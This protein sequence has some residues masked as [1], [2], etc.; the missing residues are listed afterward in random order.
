MKLFKRS[1]SVLMA[2]LM[3]FSQPLM[4]LAD[5]E[6]TEPTYVGGERLEDVPEG[7]YVYFGNAAITLQEGDGSFSVPIYR[8]G[9]TSERAWVKIHTIDLTSVYGRDYRV[10]GKHRTEHA[11]RKNIFQLLAEDNNSDSTEIKNYEF[12]I[13]NIDKASPTEVKK[14]DSAD[15]KAQEPDSYE[16]E[17]ADPD[18]ETLDGG[19]AADDEFAADD[20]AALMDDEFA[21]D[22]ADD[23]FAIDDGQPADDSGIDTDNENLKV[24]NVNQV[25]SGSISNDELRDAYNEQLA[26]L[27][28]ADADDTDKTVNNEDG[29]SNGNNTNN[30]NDGS[31]NSRDKSGTDSSKTITA[32]EQTDSRELS[33]DTEA[34][35]AE[36]I[37]QKAVVDADTDSSTEDDGISE[38]AKLKY[39]QT[40]VPTREGTP[41]GVVNNNITDQI[42]GAIA[43]EYMSLISYS[44]EQTIYFEPDEDE[45]EFTFRLYDNRKSDGSRMFSVIIAE[46][47]DNIETYKA[48]NMSVLIEDDEETAHSKLSFADEQFDGTDNTAEIKIVRSDLLQTMATAVLTAENSDTGETETL[49]ELVFSPYEKEKTIR[50]NITH[51]S[52]LRLTD[53]T[54]ADEGDIM[55]AIVTGTDNMTGEYGIAVDEDTAANEAMAL[56]DNVAGADEA[57]ALSDNEAVALA[58]SSSSSSDS[59][60]EKEFSLTFN[61]KTLTGVYKNGDLKATLYDRTYNPALAVGDYFFAAD[62]KNGG[63]FSYEP[64]H[65]DGDQPGWHG[66]AAEAFVFHSDE[67]RNN[68]DFRQSHGWAH[69]YTKGKASLEGAVRIDPVLSKASP[70]NAL[71]YQYICPEMSMQT[72]DALFSQDEWSSFRIGPKSFYTGGQ[73]KDQTAK[74]VRHIIGKFG[75]GVNGHLAVK[76]STENSLLY[77]AVG[78]EDHSAWVCKTFINFSGMVAMYKKYIISVED[79]EQRDYKSADGKSTTVPYQVKVKVGALNPTEST[80]TRDFYV[81][82]KSENSNIVFTVQA[83]NINGSIGTFGKLSGYRITIGNGNPKTDKTVN[84]PADF[85]S[86]LKDSN[87]ASTDAIDYSAEA[88]EKEVA[89]I[90]NDIAIVPVDIY[91]V[92]WMNSVSQEVVSDGMDNQ[93]WHQNLKFKPVIDYIDVNVQVTEPSISGKGLTSGIAH[94]KDSELKAGAVKTYHAGDMLDLTAVADNSAYRVIGYE[95]SDDGGVRFNHIENSTQL[96]LQAGSVKGYIIRP[97]V[98]PNE[99]YIEIKYASGADSYV[100]VDNLVPQDVLKDYPE[101]KGKNILDI[102]PQAKDIY[103]RIFPTVGRAY[104]V[105]VVFDKTQSGGKTVRATVKDSD[106]GKTYTTNK[107][108]FLA[109]NNRDNNKFEVGTQLAA[110]ADVQDYT[111]TGSAVTKAISVRQDGKGYNTLPTKGYTISLGSG[112]TEVTNKITNSKMSVVNVS[113]GTIADNGAFTLQGKS[114]S[115]GD[116]ITVLCTNGLGDDQI[117]EVKLGINKDKDG[118]Y[119]DNAGQLVMG[120]PVTAPEIKTVTYSYEKISSS[121]SVTLN[122]SQIRLLDDTLNLTAVVDNKGR[123]IDSVRFVVRDSSGNTKELTAKP[124]NGKSNN[125]FEVSVKNMLNYFHTGDKIYAYVVD[126]DS[127]TINYGSTTKKQQIVYPQVDT[128]LSTYVENEKITPKTYEQENDAKKAMPNVDLPIIGGPASGT[129]SG[130][131]TFNKVWHEGHKSYSYTANIDALYDN[132]VD[133]AKDKAN[134]TKGAA[135]SL[136]KAYKERKAKMQRR[137]EREEQ[138]QQPVER[139]ENTGNVS[140]DEDEIDNLFYRGDEASELSGQDMQDEEV[141]NAAADQAPDAKAKEMLTESYPRYA[142]NVYLCVD[143]EF[144][145]NENTNEFVLSMWSVVVGGKYSIEQV[146]YTFIAYFPVY[147]DLSGMI[148]LNVY[149]GSLTDSFKDA[150]KAG[151]FDNYSGNLK[152][153]ADGATVVGGTDATFKGRFQIGAGVMNCAGI[154]GGITFTFQFQF[155]QLG[156]ASKDWAGAVLGLS[157]SIGID[158]VVTQFNWTFGRVQKGWGTLSN[159]TQVEWLLPSQNDEKTN[160]A[161]QKSPSVDLVEKSQDDKDT[162]TKALAAAA[163][164]SLDD[165]ADNEAE[166][167][168]EAEAE[169]IEAA[170]GGYYSVSSFGLGSDLDEEGDEGFANTV[171]KTSWLKSALSLDSEEDLMQTLKVNAAERTRPQLIALDENKSKYMMLFIGKGKDSET[172]KDTAQLYYSINKRGG[173][174]GAWQTP[175]P[176]DAEDCHYDSSPDV[177]EVSPGKFMVAWLDAREPVNTDSFNTSAYTSFDVSGALFDFGSDLSKI[178][179][180]EIKKFTFSSDKTAYGD[181]EDKHYFN[182]AP[183]LTKSGRQIYCT[184]LKR[185]ISEVTSVEQLTD[186]TGSYSV[187]A[188]VCYDTDQL[189]GTELS[190]ERIFSQHWEGSDPDPY[191]T[192]YAVQGFTGSSADG[193]TES[194]YVAVAYTIDGD[195]DLRTGDDRNM[196]LSIYNTTDKL[197]YYPIKLT[198]DTKTQTMLQMNRLNGNIYLTWLEQGLQGDDG[199]YDRTEQSFSIMNI[200]DVIDTLLQTEGISEKYFYPNG[201]ATP[202][203]YGKATLTEYDKAASVNHKS[204]TR[205]GLSDSMDV[206]TRTEYRAATPTEYKET[207]ALSNTSESSALNDKVLL[208]AVRS[209]MNSLSVAYAGHAD[210]YNTPGWKYLEDGWM[211]SGNDWYSLNPE[212]MKEDI[213]NYLVA[214]NKGVEVGKDKTGK[215]IYYDRAYAESI[216]DEGSDYESID[217]VGI[218]RY[219][220]V[221]RAQNFDLPKYTAI[222]ADANGRSASSVNEYKLVADGENDIYVFF[223]DYCDN[224]DHTGQELYAMR[225]REESTAKLDDSKNDWEGESA[226]FSEPVMLTDRNKIIDEFDVQPGRSKGSIKIVS[227]LYDQDSGRNDL[228][229]FSFTAKGSV[230]PANI[231]IDEHIVKGSK[232]E[233]QFDLKNEGLYT[234][235]GCTL[236]LELELVDKNDKKLETIKVP[237]EL[238]KYLNSVQLQPGQSVSVVIPWTPDRDLDGTSLRITSTENASSL[239]EEFTRTSYSVTKAIPYKPVIEINDYKLSYENGQIIVTATVANHGNKDVS[240]LKLVL[241]RLGIDNSEDKVLITQNEGGLKSG[242]QKQVSFAYAPKVSDFDGFERIKLELSAVGDGEELESVTDTFTDSVPVVCEIEEGAERISINA[243]QTRQLEFKAAPYNELAGD[244]MFYSSDPTIAYVDSDGVLHA[245][246][247]GSVTITLY[248]PSLG[249]STS[250]EVNVVGANAERSDRVRNSD[251]YKNSTGTGTISVSAGIPGSAVYGLWTYHPETGRWTFAAGN[252]QY[253]NEWAYIYNPYAVELQDKNAWFRFDADGNMVTGWYTDTDGCIYYLWPYSDNT[254]GHMVTGWLPI[255][256]NW[257]FFNPVSNGLKGAMYRSTTT[258]DGYRVGEDGA[259]IHDMIPADQP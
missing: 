2:S 56:S 157:G 28:N 76:V 222:L 235:N 210:K 259:W 238:S 26:R 181:S 246:K 231:D 257:Y 6:S 50:L 174:A 216:Y 100:H 254:M 253:K 121:Q 237:S 190:Q 232:T 30:V 80:E 208:S 172:G 63:M 7:N 178:S 127:V 118:R 230:K 140:V 144:V 152:N 109:R 5:T 187:V 242:E 22:S 17:A 83:N 10:E 228:V 154:R 225:F 227:N 217:D 161:D 134:R 35:Q 98:A 33:D 189:D 236:E 95:I 179:K 20:A 67:A 245:L 175:K 146:Y 171:E 27:N 186:M 110:P 197:A 131:I 38:L 151:D 250:V 199:S 180:P 192:N 133:S 129:Q 243:G 202:T 54:A 193:L 137:A 8:E 88:V 194:N 176:V 203:E 104:S 45:A 206:A 55:S 62:D 213:I 36:V 70:I 160:A 43:P 142:V 72:T 167:E 184:Y 65:L 224:V 114:G 106:N 145:L 164:L 75:H 135:S 84:Y 251:R 252:R 183:Q 241:T 234:A 116:L 93:A 212:D 105:D 150:V 255:G 211:M 191:I 170:N 112:Q 107:Y 52:V 111:L 48:T 49:G 96:V 233:L 21:V 155:A 204:L 117:I 82:P 141:A 209:S 153:M 86:F 122:E 58:D 219:S 13:E 81:N 25:S 108:Y 31:N 44:C 130:L 239:F 69:Y 138:A 218:F 128:G 39:E 125:V 61:G 249:I 60:D 169:A 41:T 143:L 15:S 11:G 240:E 57:A 258:P 201:K 94:F 139:G 12:D 40:G 78:A 149:F 159:K 220:V 97:E 101:L 99:N 198:S 29:A 196:Y 23:G 215:S 147:L 1:I 168:T 248:Y 113:S 195:N 177:I 66:E 46:T 9:D 205:S 126:K 89:K 188:Y 68:K 18:A 87:R 34:A 102:N 53:L 158:L 162:Q 166:N 32:P 77:P 120:Y 85:I 37:D 90:N 47:S 221:G 173:E 19:F 51:D 92:D 79:A 3:A 256:T 119:V 163:G 244:A 185:D 247:G 14:Q 226:G 156:G 229:Y 91:F 123:D 200:S 103:E 42:F 4:T 182:L 132:I 16:A 59:S 24:T 136:Q 223:N 115:S 148:Q 73:P 207:A 74:Y 71:Y 214:A 124:Q 64:L 165:E